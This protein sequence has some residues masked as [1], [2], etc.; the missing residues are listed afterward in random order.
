MP[1]QRFFCIFKPRLGQRTLK[2]PVRGLLQSSG[3]T[4]MQA[5]SAPAEMVLCVPHWQVL[6]GALPLGQDGEMRKNVQCLVTV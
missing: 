5:V 6:A 4:G 2:K 3:G 1:G